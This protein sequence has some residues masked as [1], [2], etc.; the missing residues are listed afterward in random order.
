MLA[1]I[2]ETMTRELE[3]AL[4]AYKNMGPQ[5]LQAST[6]LIAEL[7]AIK[8]SIEDR[9]RLLGYAEQ[10]RRSIDV[11]RG[12]CCRWH[13]PRTLDRID[14]FAALCNLT[15]LERKVLVRQ[16]GTAPG[17]RYQCPLLQKNGCIFTFDNRPA[18]CTAAFP[19][20]AGEAYWH[21]KERFRKDLAAVRAAL[22]ALID[23]CAADACG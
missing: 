4:R 3:T 10:C 1:Q 6:E 18:V 14:F 2:C 19:C 15:D 12:E 5:S 17:R 11:C 23:R 21:Y 8:V 20:L 16:V 22:E 9:A 13:F 7:S